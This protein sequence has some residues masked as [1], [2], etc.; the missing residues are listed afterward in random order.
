MKAQETRKRQSSSVPLVSA[1]IVKG[2]V[3]VDRKKHGKSR[4][5]L[6]SHVVNIRE[7]T[8][9]P[10]PEHSCGNL[11]VLAI[12]ECT[13]EESQNM[14]FQDFA[15]FLGDGINK[16]VTACAQILSDHGENRHALI[17]NAVESIDKSFMNDTNLVWFTDWSQFRF[18]ETD[19]G[20]GKPIW[21]SVANMSIKNL[22]ILMDTKESDGIEAWIHLDEKDMHYFEQDE[23]I[24]QFTT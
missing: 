12:S 3:G 11:G 19:F 20:W 24:N 9:P 21:A 18:Y 5:S 13:T 10:L 8:I 23:E 1:L 6:I 2:I 17:D 7:R 16:T 14:E 15:R 4:A 22:I